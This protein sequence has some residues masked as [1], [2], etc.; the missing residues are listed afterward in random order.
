M[1]HTLNCILLA[2]V[3]LCTSSTL[4]CV[5]P[6]EEELPP[7]FLASCTGSDL[8]CLGRDRCLDLFECPSNIVFRKI[9]LA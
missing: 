3:F 1:N 2:A 8:F 5:V 9:G 7:N 4:A 6:N